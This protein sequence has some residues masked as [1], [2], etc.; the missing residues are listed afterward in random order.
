MSERQGRFAPT[1]VDWKEGSGFQFVRKGVV[2]DHKHYFD[3]E[4]DAIGEDYVKSH[5]GEAGVPQWF[6]DLQSC[7][8]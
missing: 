6:Q 1:S 8:S 2:G 7:R 3:L 4:C 5:F